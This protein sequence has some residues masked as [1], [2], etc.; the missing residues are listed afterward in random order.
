VQCLFSSPPGPSLPYLPSSPCPYIFTS[1]LLPGGDLSYHLEKEG[2][3]QVPRVRLYL[4]EI[5]LA[6]EYLRESSIIHR[7]VKPANMLLDS[8]G[9]VHLTDFNVACIVRPDVAVLSITGTKP[10]MG[11]GCVKVSAGVCVCVCER[12]S[13]VGVCMC[14]CVCVQRYVCGVQECMCVVCMSVCVSRGVCVCVC[15]EAILDI[16]LCVHEWCGPAGQ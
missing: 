2:R 7:D 15:V 11:K 5:A 12:E 3:F 13:V 1:L 14:V 10:Y 8:Q 4:A 9:H 6:L 16:S